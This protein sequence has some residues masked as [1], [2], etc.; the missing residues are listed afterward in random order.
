MPTSPG[1]SLYDLSLGFYREGNYEEAITGF[2]NFVRKYP[3]SS[4]TDNAQYWVGESYMALRQYEQ[5]ILAFQVVIKNTPKA[6]KC[7]RRFFDRHLP[8]M[9]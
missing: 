9:R 8:F 3:K 1:K 7:R 5:A 2:K 6:T 4:L